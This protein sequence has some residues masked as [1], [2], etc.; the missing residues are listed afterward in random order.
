MNR[1]IFFFSAVFIL[2]PDMAHAEILYV[3]KTG[4]GTDGTSWETAFGAISDALTA[5]ASGD[6]IWVDS[7]TYAENI[8]L[9]TGVQLYGGFIGN[10][11]LDEFD[12]RNF[13]ANET[14]IDATGT[15]ENA[16]IIYGGCV[17]DGFTVTGGG[18][19]AGSNQ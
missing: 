11:S 14:I 5:S 9:A 15:G 13:R 18:N 2:T 12:L 16:V 8:A 19:P 3:S 17:L 10:E 4:N 6:N 7:G 1:I